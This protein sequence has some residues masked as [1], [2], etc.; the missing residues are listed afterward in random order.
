M[1]KK[2][3]LKYSILFGTIYFVQGTG[4]PSDG[5][6]N[7]PLQYFLKEVMLLTAAQSAYFLGIMSMAWNIKPPYGLVS[8]F[9]PI[10]GYRRKSYLIIMNLMAFTSWITLTFIRTP[11]YWTLL[12]ILTLCSL[13]FAFSDVVCDGLMVE[14]GKPLGLTGRFQAIQWGTIS[15]ASILTGIGGGWISEH[16]TCQQA[17]MIA[18]TFPLMT[19]TATI[20]FVKEE[21]TSMNLAQIKE[22]WKAVKK[23]VSNPL[24]WGVIAFIFF[25]HFRPS[26]G[27]PFMYYMRDELKFSKLFIGILGSTESGAGV[28]GAVLYWTYCKK[29]PLKAL[30]H[31]TVILGFIAT[32]CY[33]LVVPPFVNKLPISPA[34]FLLWSGILFGIPGMMSHLALLDLSANACPKLAEGTIFAMLMSIFNTGTFGSRMLGGWLYDQVGMMPIIL[35]SALT[36]LICWP[37]IK[38]VNTKVIDKPE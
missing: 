13:G 3:A 36:A 17:F 31:F 12:P 33:V 22:T 5:I 37:L 6:A 29:I 34:A 11:V 16:L 1:D 18:G 10:F 20:L 8:D 30:L 2:T 32:I 27:S 15:F 14:T 28:I 4:S 24:I 35:I 23:G 9:F 21:K 19:V 7:Q 38:L 25:W 26:F